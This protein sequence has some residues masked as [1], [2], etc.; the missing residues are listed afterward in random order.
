MSTVVVATDTTKPLVVA[1]RLTC[2]F[3]VSPPWLERFVGRLPRQTLTA[4][5]DVS[6]EIARRETLAFVGESGSGKSTVARLVVGLLP[7]TSGQ[8]YVDGIS[9]SAPE[10]SAAREKLVTP[11]PREASSMKALG[12]AALAAMTALMLAAAVIMGPGMDSGPTVS[13]YAAHVSGR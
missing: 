10:Q 1:D 3:D 4:V 6:F 9:M 11:T 12:A 13:P 7:P 5:A 8:V 2:I